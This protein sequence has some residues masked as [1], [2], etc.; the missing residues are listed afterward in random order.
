MTTYILMTSKVNEYVAE[1]E[2]GVT[3]VKVFDHYL[4]DQKRSE[5]SVGRVEAPDARVRISELG[6]GGT[7]NS[8]PFKFFESFDSVEAAEA[9]LQELM[10]A[11]PENTR[12]QP[13]AALTGS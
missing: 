13:Q 2:H 1:P 5:F 6:E 7:V 4:F 3:I 8:I 11:D 12:I 9:E 10:D